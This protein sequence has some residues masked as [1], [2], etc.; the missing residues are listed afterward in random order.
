MLAECQVQVRDLV[1]GPGTAYKVL[2]G[3]N[4][5]TRTVRSSQGDGRAWNHG[6][7]SGA[8]WADEATVPIPVSVTATDRDIG[9]WLPLH[10]QLAAAFAPVGDSPETVE[11]R[12]VYGGV[13]YLM[14][15]RPRM[16]SPN[17]DLIS[18]GKAITQCAFVAQ[19][20]RIYSGVESAQTTG[21]PTQ[22]GGLTVPFT[23]PFHIGGTVVGGRLEL[24][25]EGTSDA[26]LLVRIDGPV[27]EPRFTLQRPDG[28]V[29]SVRFDL[30][31]P[32]DQWLIVDSAA[33]TAFVNGLPTASRRGRAAWDMDPY[34]LPPGTTTLVFGSADYNDEASI[35]AS[36]RSAWW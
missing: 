33:G 13:E 22:V 14:F 23:V 19:D 8:E 20:P 1:M 31:L 6:T 24:V 30:E 32:A 10:Q 21:L 12:W 35:T 15:G 34:P 9:S 28:T 36:H 25:N 16:V 3:F 29:Q 2:P 17:T 18:V 7:W 5:F 26:P 27:P 11:L 4:P